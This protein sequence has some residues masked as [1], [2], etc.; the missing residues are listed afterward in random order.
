MIYLHRGESLFLSISWN[1]FWKHPPNT[2]F[3][4]PNIPIV[5]VKGKLKAKIFYSGNS[6]IIYRELGGRCFWD[7]SKT[8]S[9]RYTR[10]DFLPYGGKS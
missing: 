10:L 6:G 5:E 9:S 4:N 2:V 3:L 1:Q 8:V 7:V